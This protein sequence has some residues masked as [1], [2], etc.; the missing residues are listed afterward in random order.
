MLALKN[1]RG[2][3]VL[4]TSALHGNLVTVFNVVRDTMGGI[5]D[6]DV[7]SAFKLENN[8]RQTFLAVA[9]KSSS[10]SAEGEGQEAGE[11]NVGY[12]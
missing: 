2:N 10:S 5:A 6:Q 3:T 1:R 12:V 4:H 9:V 7:R 8:D 11:E